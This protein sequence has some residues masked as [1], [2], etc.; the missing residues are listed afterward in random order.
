MNRSNSKSFIEQSLILDLNECS[1]KFVRYLVMLNI[2]V[3]LTP[4]LDY[5]GLCDIFSHKVI[6]MVIKKSRGSFDSG[7]VYA[8]HF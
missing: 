7:M 3:S 2:K 5:R 4:H 1:C 6:L 8:M